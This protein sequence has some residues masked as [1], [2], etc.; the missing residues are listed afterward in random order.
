[1]V[2]GALLP[3]EQPCSL[4]ATL[5]SAISIPPQTGTKPPSCCCHRSKAPGYQ[6]TQQAEQLRL[7]DYVFTG[8]FTGEHA[9]RRRVL[10]ALPRDPVC[11]CCVC[12]HAAAGAAHL[13]LRVPA[14]PMPLV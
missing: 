6:D 2:G 9:S 5:L 1:M 10:P 14:R 11:V 8:F 3:T 13:C 7:A 4:R 12:V